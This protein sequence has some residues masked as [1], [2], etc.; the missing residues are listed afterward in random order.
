MRLN[1]LELEAFRGATVPVTI[2]FDPAKKITMIFAENGNGKSTISDA[3]SCL[4]TDDIGSISDKSETD[5]KFLKSLG[6]DTAKIKLNTAAASF[7]ATISGNGRNI[8]KDP[9]TTGLPQLRA[10]RRKQIIKLIESK[11]NERYQTLKDFI[12]VNE[13]LKCEVELRKTKAS[14]EKELETTVSI[15]SQATDTLEKAWNDEGE[16]GTDFLT[17]AEQQS[18][19]DV[20]ELEKEAEKF[21]A[22]KTKWTAIVS[23]YDSY[24]SAKTNLQTSQSIFD[25][26][27]NELERVKQ[28]NDDNEIS[29]LKLLEQAKDYIQ[30]E[31][32]I[33]MCPVC[34]NNME[35]DN[36]LSSLSSRITAMNALKAASDAVNIAKAELDRKQSAFD[37]EVT[38]LN[39]LLNS[40]RDAIRGF[41]DE[42]PAIENFVYNLGNNAEENLSLFENEKLHLDNLALSIT[43]IEEEKTTALNQHNLI[44]TQFQSIKEN[45]AKAENLQNLVTASSDALVIVETSRKE[46]TEAELD[47]ISGEVD[48]MYNLIHPDEQIGNVKLSLKSNAQSSLV[49]GAKFH[50]EEEIQPQS[51]YSESHL[52]TLGI[53]VFLALAKKY[54]DRNT[55]LVLDDVVMSVD[56]KHLDRFIELLH[57]EAHSFGQII[58]TTHYR[59]WRDRYRNNRAPNGGVH[60]LELRNWSLENGIRVYNGKLALQE[61]KAYVENE[62][63]FNRENIASASGRMLENILDFLSFKYRCK[64]PRNPQNEY[65]LADLLNGFS[66]TLL[67]LLKVE[68]YEKDEDGNYTQLSKTVELRNI[69]ADLKDLSAVRNQVG[70]HYN[71]NGSLVSD[72]DVLELGKKTIEFAE[73]LICPENGKLPSYN[74]SGSYWETK[75]KTI[76]LFP[77]A[78]P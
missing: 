22:L 23:R 4:L 24:S 74:T 38:T 78:T 45:K 32:E 31:N 30:G 68:H 36:V 66:S 27:T 46:F 2:N 12:D 17:W 7:A 3:L 72:A 8:V 48:R 9:Q 18:H 53:C 58:M 13:I 1:S 52:D 19:K 63:D 40:Y 65:T 16:P 6:K 67:P 11:A 42:H 62:E 73:L 50:T 56:E 35:R 43:R 5:P 14:A 70:A 20:T 69:I 10:I 15:I 21:N 60:F 51:I 54:G 33:E 49:I 34:S 47:S 59:P 25:A 44:K 64:L 29:L 55:I 26:K 41:T 28:E 75:K 61:L 57:S 71:F 76:K 39:P 37:N 77:L